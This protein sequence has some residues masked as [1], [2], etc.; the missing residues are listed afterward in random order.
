M[1]CEKTKYLPII[2]NN[3]SVNNTNFS[4]AQSYIFVLWNN[5]GP[6]KIN[7]SASSVTSI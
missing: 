1:S 4:K 2:N 3:H 5:E 7:E 6:H